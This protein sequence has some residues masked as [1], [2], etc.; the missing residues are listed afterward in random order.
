M[1][2]DDAEL[3]ELTRDYLARFGFELATETD[4]RRGLS[5]AEK[6]SFAAI[7]IDVMMPVMD[8]FELVR[9]ARANGV[10]TPMIMLTARGE[11][12][13]K[14]T[15]LEMGADDYLPKP[16]EP[17]ELVA[18]LMA[19]ARRGRA[20]VAA[21][22]IAKFDGLRFDRAR[23]EIKIA[24]GSAWQ[25]VFL[26]T[27][28][29]ALLSELIASR[30]QAVSRDALSARLHGLEFDIADRSLDITV[31]RIRAKLNDDPKRPRFIKT[32]RYYGY[33]FVAAPA[34]AD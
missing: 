27:G 14:V 31:S 5:R 1:I 3:G 15:G 32:V 4:S 7:I 20:S 23:G 29:L 34:G 11:V 10:T 33:A 6:E 2:D 25:S 13:D 24:H 12:A 8:G 22:A 17:R 21:S 18:R 19:L 16:F 26:T 9:R 28:E 30:P